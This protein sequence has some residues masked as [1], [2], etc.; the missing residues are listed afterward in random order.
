[1]VYEN[2]FQGRTAIVTGGASG[3]GLSVAA[4]LAREGAAVSLLKE[5]AL[6]GAKVPVLGTPS[7]PDPR[8]AVG[9]LAPAVCGNRGHLD[10]GSVYRSFWVSR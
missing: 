9:F 7:Q 8:S 1:M 4:R 5:D 2:R 3:I 6:A 10:V